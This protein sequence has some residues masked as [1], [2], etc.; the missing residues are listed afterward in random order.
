LWK[1]R[2]SVASLAPPFPVQFHYTVSKMICQLAQSA[3]AR[4]GGAQKALMPGKIL[5]A[6]ALFAGKAN[7][8]RPYGHT[9]GS[10][11]SSRGFQTHRLASAVGASKNKAIN[12]VLR[13]I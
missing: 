6:Q 4:Q 12:T 11:C 1:N 7:A 13:R 2:F 5:S 10:R 3:G 8:L 9:Y